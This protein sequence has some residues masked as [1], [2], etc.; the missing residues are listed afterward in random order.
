LY[1]LV[2]NLEPPDLSLSKKLGL[3][4]EIPAPSITERSDER[5]W[6]EERRPGR[7]QLGSLF[8]KQNLMFLL[9][10]ILN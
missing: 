10:S 3:W 1:W 8:F 2:S 4:Y 7:I 6:V 5:T 9:G